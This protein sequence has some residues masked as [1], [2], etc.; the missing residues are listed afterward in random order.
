MEHV[1][2][3]AVLFD[4]DGT[5]V[6]DVPYN[7]DPLA[8]RPMEGAVAAVA[9]A[10]AHGLA[11]GVVSNQS[12]VGRGLLTRDQLTAVNARVDEIFGA[13]DTWQ[14]CPHTPD[15]GCHCRK[16]E[17]GLVL[18]ACAELGALPEET[19]VVGDIGGDVEA[20]ERAG[21]RSVLVPTPATRAEE[22]W[23]A[24]NVADDLPTAMRLV[25][26]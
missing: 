23:R 15:D 7:G 11:V 20:A 5:L 24:D 19:V 14:I 22:V 8:V 9:A 26:S 2:A 4:R 6:E 17:P 18:A 12:G 1:D 10:R 16:P 21:A 25:L 3:R 13:F